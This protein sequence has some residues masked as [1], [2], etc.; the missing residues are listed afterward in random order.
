MFIK[1][2]SH[3]CTNKHKKIAKKFREFV[4]KNILM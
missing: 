1:N 2:V 4:T 3:E